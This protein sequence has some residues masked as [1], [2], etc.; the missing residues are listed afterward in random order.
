MRT[1]VVFNKDQLGHGDREL[2]R[3]V[4]ETFLQKSIALQGL[5]TIVAELSKAEKVITP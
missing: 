4:L 1:V 2:G 3:E 5:E